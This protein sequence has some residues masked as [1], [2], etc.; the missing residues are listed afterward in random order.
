MNITLPRKFNHNYIEDFIA[1]FEW[2]FTSKNKLKEGIEINCR[3]MNMISV[4]GLL[5]LY[6]TM[7]FLLRYDCV[8]KPSLLAGVELGNAIKRYGF[9]DL[10]TK[11]VD[12]TK[13]LNTETIFSKIKNVRYEDNFIIAPYPLGTKDEKLFNA[14]NID[15]ATKISDY[16][17]KSK[18]S[19]MVLTCISEVLLN[20]YKHALEKDPYSIL[21]AEG[22]KSKIEIAC[23]DTGNGIISNLINVLNVRDKNQILKKALERGI[24]SKPNTFHMGR[25]LWIIKEMIK[26]TNGILHLYSEGSSYKLINGREISSSCGNWSGTIVYLNL[27]LENPVT[28]DEILEDEKHLFEDININLV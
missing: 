2:I 20:F 22:N 3:N 9:T 21:V 26:R 12:D 25:G 1:K 7:E 18:I 6:K 8:S 14:L 5:L 11:L 13:K 4:I 27:P 28:M 10:M 23:A 17:G 15:Y 16:Y 19:E 24:T